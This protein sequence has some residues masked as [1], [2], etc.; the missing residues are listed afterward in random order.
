MISLHSAYITG[1]DAESFA[2]KF[3]NLPA[4][5]RNILLGYL[6]ISYCSHAS[7]MSGP[8]DDELKKEIDI[9]VGDLLQLYIQVTCTT[10]TFS[11]FPLLLP[12]LLLLFTFFSFFFCF[13]SSSSSIAPPSSSWSTPFLLHFFSR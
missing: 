13:F 12:P 7:F 9:E 4:K 5:L 11:F 3:S 1:L 6:K 10:T 8:D 2:D